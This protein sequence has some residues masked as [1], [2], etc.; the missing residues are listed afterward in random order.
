LLSVLV[1]KLQPSDGALGVTYNE[2]DHF[3][4]TCLT[5]N[6]NIT[7][8]EGE[9]DNEL[10]D[11]A[12]DLD[13][14]AVIEKETNL[15]SDMEKLP[16]REYDLVV[17]V[18]QFYIKSKWTFED[19]RDLFQDDKDTERAEY[20]ENIGVMHEMYKSYDMFISDV[21]LRTIGNHPKLLGRGAEIGVFVV[22]LHFFD[23]I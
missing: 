13:D 16:N 1:E 21:L 17:C 18:P 6:Q 7:W 14:E 15:L 8:Q 3:I 20:K 2:G 4:E 23:V 9:L 10:D 11:E 22:S 5:K 12:D 19:D